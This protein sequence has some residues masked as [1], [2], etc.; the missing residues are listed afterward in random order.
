MIMSAKNFNS[1]LLFK[2]ENKGINIET[3][4]FVTST[5]IHPLSQLDAM[6]NPRCE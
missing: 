6:L 5:F 3:T 4:A 2:P 1:T